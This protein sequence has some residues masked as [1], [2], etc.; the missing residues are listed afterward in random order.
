M[1]VNSNV[2]TT[3]LPYSGHQRR[4][5]QVGTP[6]LIQNGGRL[7]DQ[8]LD[9]FPNRHAILTVLTLNIFRRSGSAW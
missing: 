2:T 3:N 9:T 7:I 8:E 4:T 6:V 5:V 1:P